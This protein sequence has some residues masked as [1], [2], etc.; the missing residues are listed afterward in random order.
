MLPSGSSTLS[1]LVMFPLLQPFNHIYPVRK[2]FWCICCIS[3]WS[4]SVSLVFCSV[5]VTLGVMP[6]EGGNWRL[7]HV[8]TDIHSHTLLG[9]GWRSSCLCRWYH[10]WCW[11][12][13]SGC[14]VS[15]TPGSMYMASNHG[16]SCSLSRFVSFLALIRE[17]LVPED[18]LSSECSCSPVSDW[19]LVNPGDVW[20]WAGIMSTSPA[21]YVTEVAQRLAAPGSNSEPW[22]SCTK[23]MRHTVTF[24]LPY[25]VDFND[26]NSDWK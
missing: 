20:V 19:D 18:H 26:Y 1:V 14:R 12:L 8:G 7:L 16:L 13:V 5:L 9:C 4:G 6:V 10:I 22:S 3:C 21:R 15:N 2:T 17:Q 11:L 25:I 24:R 23:V